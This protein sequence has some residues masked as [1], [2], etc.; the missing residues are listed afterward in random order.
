MRPGGGRAKGHAFEREIAHRLAAIFG[1]AKRGL[2]QT[3]GG[4]AECPDVV[5]PNGVPFWVEAKHHIRPNIVAALEQAQAAIAP[6][7]RALAICKGNRKQPTATMYLDDFEAIMRE[8]WELKQKAGRLAAASDEV[9][10]QLEA[11]A[12]REAGR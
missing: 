5:L 10:S 8:W 6:N 2:S 11:L 3:R 9:Q 1:D 7:M 12:K 4:T